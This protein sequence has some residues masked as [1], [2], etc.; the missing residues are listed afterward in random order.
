MSVIAGVQSRFPGNN[1]AAR[2]H[3]LC[4]FS[5][6]VFTRLMLCLFYYSVE[7]KGSHVVLICIVNFK[8]SYILVIFFKTL[9]IFLMYSLMFSSRY[10]KHMYYP[11]YP[12][13]C[14][15]LWP[16][17][18]SQRH[19][20]SR[21]WRPHFPFSEPSMWLRDY[22]V[23]G[24]K[25]NSISQR[26]NLDLSSQKSSSLQRTPHSYTTS[27]SRSQAKKAPSIL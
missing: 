18:C 26:G 8:D 24:F 6:S 12:F 2:L 19:P 10:Y 20:K 4:V 27:L 17:A 9:G 16:P 21:K 1:Q 13:L 3:L 7:I 15:L 11:H 14:I 25:T 22:H 23:P 5:G